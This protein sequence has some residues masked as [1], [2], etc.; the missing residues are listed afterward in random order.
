MALPAGLAVFPAL[1]FALA[2]LLWSPGRCAFSR[3]RSGLGSSE[4]ARGLL[5]TGF[6]W[7]DLGMAL[8]ANLA[9][10]QIASLVGLHGLT[11]PRDRDLRR[12]GDAVASERRAG[13]LA[14]TV[15]A[16]LALD[17]HGRLRRVPAHGAG[18]PDACRA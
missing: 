1:G 8:G 14:P 4:W 9:L 18:E 7:N 15:I 16:A 12:A 10:A 6:P 17:A 13:A 11:L 3:S 5:F 2:R